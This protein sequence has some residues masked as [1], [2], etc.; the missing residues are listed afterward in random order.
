MEPRKIAI[1]IDILLGQIRG[2]EYY[3]VLNLMRLL[4]ELDQTN[5]YIL[6]GVRPLANLP[7]E[8]H[9]L[10]DNFRLVQI[11]S[12]KPQLTFLAWHAMRWPLVNKYI[13][14]NDIVHITTPNIFPPAHSRRL[15]VTVYDL[16]WRHFPQGLNRWGLFF[17]RTGCAIA[18]READVIVTISDATRNDLIQYAGRSVNPA[19][20]TTLHIDADAAQ[21]ADDSAYDEAVL[22]KYGLSE[23]YILTIGTL[24]PRKN[25]VRL[26][27]AYAQLAPS[28]HAQYRLVLVGGYGWK[29]PSVAQL[30]A[31]L[32]I[33][34]RVLWTGYVSDV[35]K[36]VLLRHA[37]IFV[38]PSLYEGFGIPILEA[39]QQDVPVIT[40]NVS[41][42]PEVAG[43]AAL[44]VDPG[45]TD[46]LTHAMERLLNN[47][48]LQAELT[49]RGVVQREQFSYRRMAEEY[50]RLYLHE[51]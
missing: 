1:S 49:R 21:R 17:A 44:L 22:Q 15:I 29:L 40:S 32:N 2:G 23:P 42:M 3:V 16:V 6:F 9:S 35:E 41:S 27:H 14:C 26:L 48:Q 11:P 34:D 37:K 13:G 24:E 8:L 51:D 25:I 46:A 45:N 7:E 19:K 36:R 10:P 18:A 28:L 31:E 38:Y 20:V 12:P 47:Q 39:F 50:L 43:D 4:R 30:V 33:G 5:R